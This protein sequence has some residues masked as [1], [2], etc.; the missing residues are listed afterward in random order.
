M[1]RVALRHPTLHQNIGRFQRSLA[2]LST[3]PGKMAESER[4]KRT[5]DMDDEE[6][7]EVSEDVYFIPHPNIVFGQTFDLLSTG[8]QVNEGCCLISNRYQLLNAHTTTPI[9]LKKGGYR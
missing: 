8:L 9:R 7:E 1:L 4:W 6:E 2:T 3:A 5:D